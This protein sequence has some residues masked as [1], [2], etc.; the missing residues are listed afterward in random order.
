MFCHKYVQRNG[1]KDLKKFIY[2]S[3]CGLILGYDYQNFKNFLDFQ[4]KVV[5]LNIENEIFV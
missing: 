2:T 4:K 3:V 5:L 1:E